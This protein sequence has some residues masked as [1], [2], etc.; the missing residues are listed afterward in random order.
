M[1]LRIRPGQ[2]F[3]PRPDEVAEEIEVQR[4]RDQIARA[5]ER[6]RRES[7]ER[8]DY[9]WTEV[10]PFHMKKYGETEE[11]ILARFPSIKPRKVH[12]VAA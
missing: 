8:E 7:Q 2:R 6:S 5:K 9:F 12:E 4:E 11:Q 3:F 1:A 10:L